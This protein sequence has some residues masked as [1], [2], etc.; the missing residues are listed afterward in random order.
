MPNPS[1]DKNLKSAV[2]LAFKGPRRRLGSGRVRNRIRHHSLPRLAHDLQVTDEH[3]RRGCEEPTG[4]ALQN[5]VQQPSA[6]ASN[7]PHCAAIQSKNHEE[8]AIPRG[9]LGDQVGDAGLEPVTS[10][11]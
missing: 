3:F 11:V 4:K 5:P 1:P 2:M 9:S 10:A 7:A 6:T 8:I